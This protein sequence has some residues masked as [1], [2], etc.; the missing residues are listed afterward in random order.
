MR[1]IIIMLMAVIMMFSMVGITTAKSGKY[2]VTQPIKITWWHAHEV[3]FH[4][5]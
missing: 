3:Q 5:T 4:D 1:K 2:D